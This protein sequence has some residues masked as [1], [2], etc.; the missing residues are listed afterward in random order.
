MKTPKPCPYETL[1]HYVCEMFCL[2]HIGDY[3]FLKE[4]IEKNFEVKHKKS[5]AKTV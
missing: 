5:L 2:D 1:A 3:E 4:F